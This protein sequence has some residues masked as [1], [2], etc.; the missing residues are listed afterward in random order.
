MTVHEGSQTELTKDLNIKKEELVSEILMIDKILSKIS[1][2]SYDEECKLIGLIRYDDSLQPTNIFKR[3]NTVIQRENTS[4]S[5]YDKLNSLGLP[6][7][8]RYDFNKIL[9]DK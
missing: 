5:M 8:I 6:T 3:I 2:L 7:G 1:N 9:E 4:R